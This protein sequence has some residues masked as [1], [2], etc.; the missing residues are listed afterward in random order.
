LNSDAAA[1]LVNVRMQNDCKLSKDKR[2][3]YKHA[4]DGTVRIYRENG[5]KNDLLVK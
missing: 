5:P 2:R 4:I 1:D 3:N